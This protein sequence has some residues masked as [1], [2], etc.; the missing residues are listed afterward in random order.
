MIVLFST[1][2][3]SKSG[4]LL[5]LCYIYLRLLTAYTEGVKISE[6]RTG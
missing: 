2:L 3:F 4:C 6:V 1:L 5:E